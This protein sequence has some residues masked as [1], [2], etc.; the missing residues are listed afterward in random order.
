MA[1]S[2]QAQITANI[3]TAL[4]T[5]S[6]ANGYNYDIAI[7]E[8][9]RKQLEIN[10]R[11]PYILLLENEPDVDAADNLVIR[12]LQFPCWFFSAQ[13]DEL[14][15]TPA[16]DLNSEIAY[17]NRNAI[18]DITKVLCATDTAIYRGGNAELTEVIPGTHESYLDNES[19]LIM[20]GTW[21]LIEVTTNIDAR[22]PYQLTQ[23]GG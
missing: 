4:G 21:C 3:K 19:G 16:E 22:N 1:D 6:V 9:A 11:W 2:I 13:N 7:V 8:Q 12:K 14:S 10:N 23:R 15:G 5:I 20:F 18:A 17:Y